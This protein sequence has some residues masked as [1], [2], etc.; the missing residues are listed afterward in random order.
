[1]FGGKVEKD[2][3]GQFNCKIYSMNER[4]Q[5]YPALPTGADEDEHL[6]Q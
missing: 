3:A 1:M 5:A 6:Q 2:Q 4:Y